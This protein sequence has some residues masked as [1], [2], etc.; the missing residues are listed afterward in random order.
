VFLLEKLRPANAA[1]P[2]QSDD[3]SLTPR[4]IDLLGALAKGASYKEAA[5]ALDISPLTVGSYV[6]SIYRK[7]EVHSR[8]EAV[9][10]AIRTRKL[11]FESG[12]KD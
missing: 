7:L 2:P 5:R 1:T 3:R 4:E 9:Y 12:G 6:K 8:G 11:N 10:E